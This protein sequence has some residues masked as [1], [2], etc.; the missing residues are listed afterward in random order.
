[1]MVHAER[2]TTRLYSKTYNWSP[3]LAT[4]INTVRYWELC[5]KRARGSIISQY[6]LQKLQDASNIE[7]ATLP[8]PLTLPTIVKFLRDARSKVTENKQNHDTLRQT[9]LFS[10]AEA[11][12]AARSPHLFHPS[13]L[14]KLEKVV[15]QERNSLSRR[16]HRRKMFQRIGKLLHP[17]SSNTGGLT[18]VDIPAGPSDKPFPLGPDPKTWTGPWRSV[19][20]PE[21]IAEHMCCKSPTVPP[22]SRYSLCNGTIT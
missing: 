22:S 14:D 12:V 11:R 3:A 2:S 10:L 18:R 4:M 5:L 21:I 15:T 20:N 17:D 19:T 9:H 6:R 1:M 13:N 16:E 8:N 7:P